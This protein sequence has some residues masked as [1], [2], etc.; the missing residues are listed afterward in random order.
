MTAATKHAHALVVE[1]GISLALQVADYNSQHLR[2][3]KQ[4]EYWRQVA[5]TLRG[6]AAERAGNEKHQST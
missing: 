2:R 1:M 3:T 5:E 4:A 6:I